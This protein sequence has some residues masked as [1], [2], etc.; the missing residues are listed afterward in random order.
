MIN[1]R[2]NAN[3]NTEQ[4]C[5]FY[6]QIFWACGRLPDDVAKMFDS[7]SLH[8]SVW[9]DGNLIGFV[10]SVTYRVY[11]AL[12]DDLIVSTPYQGQGIGTERMRRID[13]ELKMVDEVL[14]MCG[15]DVVSFYQRLGYTHADHL[16]LKKVNAGSCNIL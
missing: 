4:L 7:I 5:Q 9:D 11:R 10:R 3:I 13:S 14:L 8:V 15:S 2:V 16:C 12:V 6:Q 1:S